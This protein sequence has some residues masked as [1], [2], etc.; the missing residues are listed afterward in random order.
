MPNFSRLADMG[1]FKPLATSTP[2]HTP[3]AF[4]NIISGADPGTHQIF[5]FIH[6][7]PSPAG[8]GRV[9]RPYS[10]VADTGPP[11]GNLTLRL[12]NR[13]LPLAG[14]K[15][16]LLRKGP[17]FWDGLTRKGI[18]S[19]VYYVPSNYPPRDASGPGRFKC[20]SGMGTP[21]LLG[22]Y[23]EFAFYS[24]DVPPAGKH[25]SG[26][27]LIRLDVGNHR[28]AAVLAGPRNYTVTPDE[29]GHVPPMTASFQVVRDSKWGVAKITIG[30]H[31]VLLK[32]GEWSDW[33]PV[34]FQTHLPGST[35]L[36]L[37]GAPTEVPGMV[38]FYLKRAHPE[39]ELYATP[40]NIDPARSPVAISVPMGFSAELVREHGR[41]HT[42][43]IPE[44]TKALEAGVLD[45][46]EFLD[47]AHFAHDERT[48]QY[49]RALEDT[50]NGLL[51]FYFGTTDLVSH[52]FWRDRDPGHPGHNPAQGDKYANVIDDLYI[53]MDELVGEVMDIL[54]E[55][56]TLIVLSDH[57]FTSFRRAVNLNTWL[58]EEGY[59]VLAGSTRP[60]NVPLF[61]NV[62]WSRTRAY[63]LGLNSLFVNVRGRESK[64]IISAGKSHTAMMDEIA[65]KLAALRDEDGEQV[66]R[67]VNNAAQL[68]PG[69]DAR[70]T[71]DLIIGYADSYR[72][73]WESVLGGF[74]DST[75]EDNLDRWSG[76]HCV[77]ADLVPGI[78]L[79]NRKITA[80]RPELCDITATI[81]GA[82][83]IDAMTGMTGRNLFA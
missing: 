57:G 67:T 27:R 8:T 73:S 68:Y 74:S 39:L 82:C 32:N 37:A 24:S 2:P 53:K 29:N 6:R 63:A 70:L 17:A 12:G 1:S 38:R 55:E 25:V 64:G 43:G 61:E 36:D 71:P 45:E 7:D 76:D 34:E 49:R 46:D 40:V 18:D 3:V 56:D 72:V 54:R 41:F 33:L 22:T 59:L 26:G 4:A 81:C 16:S 69:A 15:T 79:T 10:S 60:R 28:A 47:Q 31:V 50:G 66:V 13:R 58:L 20:V 44:D 35:V 65:E 9:L 23:G 51:F 5:D 42:L 52:M 19:T 80:D 21:D 62:D 78:L 48:K 77:A 75:I 11:D 30:P 14:G 83:G